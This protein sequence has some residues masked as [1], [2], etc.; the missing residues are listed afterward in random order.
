MK[1]I[2]LHDRASKVN[3]RD[4]GRP[5]EPGEG[6]D[7]FIDGLPD[8]LAA[9]DFK[10]F[11]ARIRA[12]RRKGR[13]VIFALGA[14]VIKVG[15]NPVIIR[16]MRDGWITGLALNGAG[17]IHDFEIAYCGRTSEDVPSR[18]SSGM[19]GVARETGEWLNRAIREGARRGTGLGEAV[20]RMM[21]QSQSRLPHRSL[22]LIF[23]ARELGIPV[24]VH[25]AVGT[26]TIHF[27]PGVSGE[28]LGKTSLT[29]FFRFCTL[30]ENL[31]G[32]GV[33]VN[34]GSA[35][36]LPEV[37][38]KALSYNRNRGVKL[39]RFSTAVFDFI[40]HYR[41]E[42]NVVR[43]PVAK[44]GKGFYFIGHHEIM[45]PLLAAGLASAS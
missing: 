44:K 26:D 24:S 14:H 37:F 10:D 43:R 2:P 1:T 6:L 33:Y 4:F 29:D 18:I 39:E 8:I 40:H 3:I 13:A 36:V 22:S 28:A 32:G 30:L 17:I 25:V 5:F 31:E 34:V 41:P 19:F 42:Q 23:S 20:G 15:L 9:K 11:L 35:V 16:L 27:H 45:I 12:A 38:L 21:A 7:A